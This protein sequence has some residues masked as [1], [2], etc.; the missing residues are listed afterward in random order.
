MSIKD[1]ITPGKWSFEPFG[2]GKFQRLLELN[3]EYWKKIG[4]VD[5]SFLNTL[6]EAE[7]IFSLISKAPEMLDILERLKKWSQY[8]F[9]EVEP[10]ESAQCIAHD[11]QKLINQLN[12]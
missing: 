7:A 5:L 2:R 1:K 4:L 9:A 11:A 8:D 3:G 6:E 10:E 12:Q